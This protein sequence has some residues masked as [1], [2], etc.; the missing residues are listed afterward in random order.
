MQSLNWFLLFSLFQ[1]ASSFCCVR[2]DI[3][4][5][6]FDVIAFSCVCDARTG[7]S[8][9]RELTKLEPMCCCEAV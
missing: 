7:Q 1:V 6:N 9:N 3:C 8:L 5:C 2:F 4:N